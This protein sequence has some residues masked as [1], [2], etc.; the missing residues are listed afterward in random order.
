V[1]EELAALEQLQNLDLKNLE[2]RNE[3]EKIPQNIEE[4]RADVEHVG[5]ILERER[6]RLAEAE[7]WRRD[8]EREIEIQNELIA[9]SKAKLQ[10][11]RNEKEN[12]AA[13]REIDTIRRTIQ[14]REK[15]ALEVMEAIE[16]YRSAIEEHTREFGE[17][18]AALKATEEEGRKRMAEVE[19]EL[20]R[21]DSRR[22]ELSAAV[23]DRLLRQYERIHKR[24][25]VALVECVEGHCTGCN[26]ELL[27]Q[28][29]IELQRGDKI[30]SCPTCNR[31]LVFKG[32]DEPAS[33][34]E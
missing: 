15:E 25:G 13:Q 8:R 19:L 12:K 1:Q 29:Y 21:T 6:Q 26:M 16:S 34:G 9:K 17:L 5:E 7:E 24:L 4:M 31:I 18:E 23:P 33:G 27:P 22:K 28:M 20:G 30:I 32:N 10:A 14:E 2:F 11:A 3:L